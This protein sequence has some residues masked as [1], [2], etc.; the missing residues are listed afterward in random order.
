MR[1]L[2]AV[3]AAVLC[4]LLSVRTAYAADA[5]AVQLWSDLGALA[6]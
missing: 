1:T 3:L 6:A 2:L 5:D 4:V